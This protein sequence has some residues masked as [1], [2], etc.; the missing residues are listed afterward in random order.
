MWNIRHCILD[1]KATEWHDDYN[2][3]KQGIKDLEVMMQNVILS[4]FEGATTIES[5]VELLDIFHNMV[6]REAIKRTLEKK[7]VDVYQMLLHE[8]NVV[9]IEFETHRKTPDIVRSQPDFAGSAFW[10]K[11]LLKRIQAV[12]STLSAAY[13]LPSTSLAEEAKAQYDPLVSSLEDYI[14]KTHSE[15]LLGISPHL[16]EKLDEVLMIHRQ[17]EALEMKFDK[18][19]FRLFGEIAYFQKL[20]CD[21]PFHIQ[22]IYNKKEELRV[23]R[24]NVLLVIR[25]YNNIVETLSSQE[26]LLF[27][28]RIKFLDRKINPGLTNLTW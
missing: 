22:D 9:K 14:S 13:F 28:E 26:A 8:L 10:A 3:F 1:V 5:S 19:L 15:W 21:S 17:G 25:D 7:T 16:A 2:N 27:K 11:S 24:E 18:D 23:L 20:K 6:K 4:S 12:M